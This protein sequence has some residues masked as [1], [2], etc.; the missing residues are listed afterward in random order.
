M[1]IKTNYDK[2]GKIRNYKFTVCIGRDANNKQLWATRTVERPEGLTPSKELKEISRLHDEWA[3]EVKGESA[4]NSPAV[5]KYR[6]TYFEFVEKHW[7]PDRVKIR[8]HTPSTIEFYKNTVRYSLD[9]FGEKKKLSKI[10]REDVTRF[11]NYLG[12]EAKTK[13]GKALSD[14]TV[15]HAFNTLRNVLEY[16]KRMKYINEDPC[17]ALTQFEKPSKTAKQVDFLSVD[18]VKKLFKC[19]NAET[20][21]MDIRID[22]CIKSGTVEAQILSAETDNER[23][24]VYHNLFWYCFIRLLIKSGLRRGEALGLQWIDIN[25]ESIWVRRNVSV[26]NQSE[27][28]FSIGE[29]KTKKERI[30]C[31]PEELYNELMWLK[32]ARSRLLGDNVNVSD[33]S[34]VFSKREDAFKPINPNVPTRWLARFTERNGLRSV[35]PHD[36]RHTFS[37]LSQEAGIPTKVV[38]EQL[39]HSSE[40]TTLG[41][42]TGVSREQQLK[43]AQ[44]IQKLIG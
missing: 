21:L 26:D 41:N 1:A 31:I 32:Q 6:I 22:D 5:D 9:Y 19:L 28:K 12:T 11:I 16:A 14:G 36:L 24:T 23:W 29:T 44:V 4:K 40:K 39:G 42:Y 35:S 18:E 20:Q 13:G 34:F 8:K 25:T 10:S 17:Q 33:Y 43:N 27:D 15:Q 3:S 37:T 30:V 2:N 38:Q 7:L